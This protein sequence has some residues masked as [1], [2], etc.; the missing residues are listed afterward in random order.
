MTALSFTCPASQM[1]VQQWLD[2]DEGAYA[3][4]YVEIPC[5]ACA[6]VHFVNRK[7]EVLGDDNQFTSKFTSS[8]P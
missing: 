4:Y 3:D 7:G 2:G 6:G 8:L 5:Q 1:K